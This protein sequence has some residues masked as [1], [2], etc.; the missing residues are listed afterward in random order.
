MLPVRRRDSV[1]RSYHHLHQLILRGKLTLP[2][3]NHHQLLNQYPR[4]VAAAIAPMLLLVT[5]KEFI[6]CLILLSYPFFLDRATQSAIMI[7][8]PSEIRLKM[9]SVND[10]MKVTRIYLSCVLTSRRN[11][12]TIMH[13]LD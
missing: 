1:K 9:H 5:R 12:S 10:L 4:A 13:H 11:Q 6:S 7:D 2:L 8:V 3:S